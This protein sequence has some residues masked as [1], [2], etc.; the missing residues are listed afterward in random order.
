[1]LKA[2]FPV[3]PTIAPLG[4]PVFLVTRATGPPGANRTSAVP[5]DG[6]S[7]PHQLLGRVVDYISPTSVIPSVSL[8]LNKEK[9]LT[10]FTVIRWIGCVLV[11]LLSTV[12][13]ASG[14]TVTP[15]TDGF[16]TAQPEDLQPFEGSSSVRILSQSSQPGMYVQ[17]ITFT[18]GR[19]TRP[20]F[21]DQAR[22]ITVIKGTW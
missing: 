7:G 3:E 6:L 13:L 5:L 15:D 1:M 19:G 9:I 16:I 14:Q 21:H 20:H 17:R 10:R 8:E 4:V 2:L 11:P 12:A 22:Y 18:P